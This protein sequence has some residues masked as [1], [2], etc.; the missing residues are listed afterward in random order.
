MKMV[1]DGPVVVN[2]D[3][4]VSLDV[5]HL[6][7]AIHVLKRHHPLQLRRSHRRPTQQVTQQVIQLHSQQTCL[8]RTRPYIPPIVQRHI[9]LRFRRT[10]RQHIPQ[11]LQHRLRP[12]TQLSLLRHNPPMHLQDTRVL[13]QPK[14]QR[15]IQRNILLLILRHT[16]LYIRPISRRNIPLNIQQL[17]PHRTR[18][19]TQLFIRHQAL[20]DILPH[21]QPMHRHYIHVTMVV[22]VV[23]LRVASV[24]R[25]AMAGHVDA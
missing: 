7:A 21:I 5:M 15:R 24:T 13:T 9:Q 4:C 16:P 19:Y 8:L 14:C 1:V 25:M 6:S 11:R 22:T 10:I 20:L 18:R 12:R 23:T 2:W 3:T 17:Y